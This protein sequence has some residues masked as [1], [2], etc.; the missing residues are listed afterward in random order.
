[1]LIA[2]NGG[3]TELIKGQTSN[4]PLFD[5]PDTLEVPILLKM[6]D[7]ISTDGILKR[8]QVLPLR[9]NIPEISKYPITP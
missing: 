9:S 8:E 3:T 2:P 4:S 1:M 6:G 5:E 7:D